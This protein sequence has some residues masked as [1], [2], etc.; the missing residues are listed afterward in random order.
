MSCQQ[1]QHI[2]VGLHGLWQ[3]PWQCVGS[4][5]PA[6]FIC[7]RATILSDALQGS[8]QLSL[9]FISIDKDP[10]WNQGVKGS[11]TSGAVPD[12]YFPMRKGCHVTLYNDA[13]VVSLLPSLSI[14]PQRCRS[15]HG[16]LAEG[17]RVWCPLDN[18]GE[19]Y[20]CH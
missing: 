16:S 4:P 11:G 14:K 20:A 10:N 3:A 19:P 18:T 1:A 2:F 6:H 13:H 5:C 9:Q 12:V 17:C 7:P 15:S 8:I